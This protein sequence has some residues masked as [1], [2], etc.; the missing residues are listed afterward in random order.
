MRGLESTIS[1][2]PSFQMVFVYKDKEDRAPIGKPVS[3]ALIVKLCNRLR[4]PV[5][6]TLGDQV[7]L[8]QA[9]NDRM[10]RKWFEQ[11][12]CFLYNTK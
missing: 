2:K 1:K 6:V 8:R 5:E 10:W 11:P 3:K 4:R 12:I 7:M 9:K